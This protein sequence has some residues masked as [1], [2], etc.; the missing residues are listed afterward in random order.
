MTK[1]NKTKR[2]SQTQLD[3]IA[4]VRWGKLLVRISVAA[5]LFCLY[6][7]S[8]AVAEFVSEL[9][10]M[11]VV[12]TRLIDNTAKKVINRLVFGMYV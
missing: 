6:D 4:R 12:A 10:C 11:C 2:N 5:F 9:V 3:R 7:R 8:A 1:Q